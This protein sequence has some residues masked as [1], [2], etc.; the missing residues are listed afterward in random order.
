M[1]KDRAGRTTGGDQEVQRLLKTSSPE[2]LLRMLADEGRKENKLRVARGSLDAL[3][4]DQALPKGTG[5][6]AS[7]KSAGWAETSGGIQGCVG[8]H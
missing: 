7:R 6:G 2:Q 8:L 1:V 5:E 4:K 3:R